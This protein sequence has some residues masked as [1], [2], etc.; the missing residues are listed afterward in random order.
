MKT[1]L[2]LFIVL[3][4]GSFLN[5][6]QQKTLSKEEMLAKLSENNQS[7]KISQQEFME[8]RSDFRQTNALFIPNI[9]ISHTGTSTNNPVY[10][11]MAKLNQGV[12]SESDFAIDNLNNPKAIDNF[13]TSISFEQPLINVDGWK[14]RSAAKYVME[15]TQY[16]NAFKKDELLLEGEKTYMMLQLSYKAVSVLEKAQKA[17]LEN[18]KVTR[19]Y[20]EQGLLLQ[21]DVLDVELRVN[22]VEN[23]L[24]NAKSNVKN[25][26]DYLH[27][28]IN[29]TPDSVFIP[30][31]SLGIV[32]NAIAKVDQISTSRADILAIEKGTQA[33]KMKNQSDKMAFLPTLNAFGNYELYDNQVFQGATN[34][35][36]IGA[37][38]N[39][40]ILQGTKRFGK[41][42]KSKAELDKSM[43]QYEQ[44]VAK[45]Q[46]ELNRAKRS[47]DDVQ[48]KLKRAGLAL[49]LSEESFRI[50]TNRFEEG[51]VKTSDL[52]T[53]EAQYAQKQLEYYQTIYEYNV[54]NAYVH[55]LTK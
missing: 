55:F 17:A 6:Q 40:D 22:E 33:Y 49:E 42:Q 32:P 31:D 5:A 14:Q 35:Y 54:A 8:A 24:E 39:W 48:N 43:L 37:K 12:F 23:Q 50:R 47:L 27:F 28:L 25:V 15:A 1:Y 4:S 44:Y 13:T 41:S 10:A 18:L 26:S 53:S 2:L 16:Q 34:S 45:S 51:L 36:F 11:F 7:I 3:L 29:E 52:L 46:L 9:S 38:L 30:S 21:S 20:F 19:K